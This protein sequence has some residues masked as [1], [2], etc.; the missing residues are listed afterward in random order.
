MI[1]RIPIFLFIIA[2]MYIYF[3]DDVFDNS[4]ITIGSSMPQTGII[5]AWGSAVVSGA[6]SYFKYTNDNNILKNKKI[7]FLVYDDKYEPELTIDNINKLI[8]QDEVFALFGF[9]GTPTVK[10]ILPV[11]YDKEIP[12]VGAFTGASF[13]RNTKNN[14]FI[15]FRSSY[16]EEIEALVS[17]L[18]D[19]K[20]LN[21]IAVFYQNDDYGE[22]VVLRHVTRHRK[23]RRQTP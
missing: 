6:N 16:K 7:N 15:N 21:K 20:K 23:T 10:N 3:R 9:V 8:F 11:L 17:Y 13:L 22:E 5:K 14:N 18:H 19:T 1:K 4:K 2:I 12:F